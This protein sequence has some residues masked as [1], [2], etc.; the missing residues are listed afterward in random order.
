[1]AC[2]YGRP[3]RFKTLGRRALGELNLDCQHA[4]AELTRP[5]GASI[6]RAGRRCAPHRASTAT[7]RSAAACKSAAM[8]WGTI[9]PYDLATLHNAD[10]APPRGQTWPSWP[11]SPRRQWHR[12]ASVTA[13]E[14]SATM[15]R[16]LAPAAATSARPLRCASW[17][18]RAE[19]GCACRRSC[20]CRHHQRPAANDRSIKP[21]RSQAPSFGSVGGGDRLV[22][23]GD[24]G[25]GPRSSGSGMLA[26]HGA[27]IS[28]QAH[29]GKAMVAT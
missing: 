19:N 27:R 11:P 25:V 14:P 2:K 5:P 12:G 3:P 8:S 18:S 13:A 26:P 6:F 9:R 20:A 21:C 7:I 24:L 4:V 22:D 29:R 10:D 17:E 16:A 23:H 1:M 28:P 15:W